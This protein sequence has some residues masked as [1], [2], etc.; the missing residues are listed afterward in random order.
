MTQQPEPPSAQ[1]AP[2]PQDERAV[3]EA[4]TLEAALDAGAA[5]LG[6]DPKELAHKVLREGSRG[7]FGM[8]AT[9]WQVEVFRKQKRRA[10]LAALQS[11]LSEAVEILK[12]RD[13]IFEL[14]LEGSDVLL[15]V[16]PPKGEGAAVSFDEVVRALRRPGMR[17]VDH[18]AVRRAIELRD[19][20]NWV[21]VADFDTGQ[22]FNK[23]AVP[24][25]TVSSDA[26]KAELAVEPPVGDGLH[27]TADAVLAAIR[28]KGIA[29]PPNLEAIKDYI[30]V[31]D[32]SRPVTVVVGI[33]SGDPVNGSLRWLVEEGEPQAM[34]TDRSGRV[35]HKAGARILSV[36]AGQRLGEILPAQ[37]G[38]P[39]MNVFG[40]P[41]PVKQGRPAKPACGKG[42]ALDAEGRFFTAQIEGQ[43]VLKNNVPNIYQV[44]EVPGNVDLTTGNIDFVGN[45]VVRGNIC[46]GFQV[47]AEG[48][49]HVSGAVERARVESGDS[50]TI[51]GGVLGKDKGIVVAAREIRCRFAENAQLHAGERVVCEKALINCRVTAGRAVVAR[52]PGGGGVIV[53]GQVM[54]GDEIEVDTLGSPMGTKTVVV[55]GID[56]SKQELMNRLLLQIAQADEQLAKVRRYVDHLAGFESRTAEEEKMYQDLRST[57]ELLSA[58]LAQLHAKREKMENE[59][60]VNRRGVIRAYKVVHPDVWVRIRKGMQMISTEIK[61]SAIGYDGESMR[62]L[63]L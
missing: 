43:F 19:P 55:V 63:P 22:Q 2:A 33:P 17:K 49:I 48:S 5:R 32:Y 11:T 37:D 18:D 16:E 41:L 47:K 36:A 14:K 35:D 27:P 1:A 6:V 54:A 38:I 60:E 25:V 40:Q 26:M 59:I 39:G 58:Q 7:L 28:A 20:A 12:S 52:G 51:G 29:L 50:I 42:V 62:I 13:G 10:S 3:V 56:L 44:F 57:L 61:A 30:A 31:K 4:V 45:V 15:R 23:D 34:Q 9:A 21:R 46:D 24:V 8:G 53:G